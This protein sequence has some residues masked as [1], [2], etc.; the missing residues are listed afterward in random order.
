[1]SHQKEAVRSGYWP[2]YRYRPTSEE[3]EHPF[4]LDS[5]APSIPLREFAMQEARYAMLQRSDPERA[6]RLMELAQ[7]CI[8][9]RWQYYEQL[10]G[11]ERALHRL[12]DV[13]L[14][15]GGA[16]DDPAGSTSEEE[17]DNG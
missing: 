8:D 11:V 1:M 6:D 16:P 10:A 17:T 7:Q 4:Q 2:L 9:E 13:P 14:E 5:A 3:H 15:V 12:E